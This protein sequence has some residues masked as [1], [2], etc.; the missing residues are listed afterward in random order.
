MSD[1]LETGRKNS[2]A[3]IGLG[4]QDIIRSGKKLEHSD[5]KNLGNE[6]NI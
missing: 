5:A 4:G 6:E 1:E 3:W 2:E